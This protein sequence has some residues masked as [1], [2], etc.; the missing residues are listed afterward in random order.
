MVLS[1]TVPQ[2]IHALEKV[3][4]VLEIIWDICLQLVAQLMEHVV[5]LDFTASTKLVLLT[6]T[7]VNVTLLP[8]AFQED[9]HALTQLANT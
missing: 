9:S 2:Q 3:T 4:H 6:P 7:E 8:I 5:L 1:S